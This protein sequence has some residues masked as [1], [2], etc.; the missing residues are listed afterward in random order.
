[1]P[2]LALDRSR[3]EIFSAIFAGHPLILRLKMAGF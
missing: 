3:S 1:M 2:D